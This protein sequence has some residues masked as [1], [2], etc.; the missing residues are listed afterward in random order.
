MRARIAVEWLQKHP[1]PHA[2]DGA[3]HWYP[4]ELAAE[5]RAEIAAGA[6]AAAT[7]WLAPGRVTWA[8]RFF[9]IAPGD[10]RRY[11]GIAAVVAEG[12]ASAA[13][14]A[15][16]IAVPAA[17]PWA[18]AEVDAT[19][20]EIVEPDA[21]S[22]GGGDPSLAAALWDGGAC[23]AASPSSI[24]VLDTW[25]PDEVR[26]RPRRL[27]IGGEAAA[28]TPVARWLGAAAAARGPALARA[29]RAWRAVAAL[30]AVERRPIPE[31]MVELTGLDDA[32]RT[33]AT[34]R[35][36]LRAAG[37]AVDAALEVD[38]DG[39]RQWAR[40]LNGWG[41]GRLRGP[42]AAVLARRAAAELLAIERDEVDRWRRVVRWEALLPAARAD[43]LEAAVAEVLGA[44]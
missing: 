34:L 21:M 2:G 12:D 39:D 27:T 43:E 32:W 29:R 9:E 22:P 16:A 37:I 8:R 23:A 36:Y 42:V 11:H 1:T 40:A 26:A 7:V 28:P 30:A 33:A 24:A 13:A 17:R 6:A 35:G 41:R 14:L 10:G 44:A 19:S 5:L 20:C 25:M 31:L 3:F 18:G 4:G 38:G 15:E